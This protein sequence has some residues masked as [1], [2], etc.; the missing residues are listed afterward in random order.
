MS[1]GKMRTPI[2]I[3]QTTNTTGADGFA[4][5]AD[6]VV[7]SVRAYREDR[8]GSEYWLSN[9]AFSQA[10]CLFRFRMIPHTTITTEMVIQSGAD[11]FRIESVDD[12]RQR[13]RYVECLCDRVEPSKR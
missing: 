7:V 11:R 2:Q 12:V 1:Y 5:T 6:T 3:L 8:H 13:H 9:A 4:T 10:T